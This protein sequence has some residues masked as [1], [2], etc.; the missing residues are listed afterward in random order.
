MVRGQERPREGEMHKCIRQTG[1]ERI[2]ARTTKSAA[3]MPKLGVPARHS[4]GQPASAPVVLH[5][6]S[7]ANVDKFYKI[8][9]IHTN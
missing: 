9:N 3:S 5:R 7:V 1:K 4:S 8:Y 2:K 6:N